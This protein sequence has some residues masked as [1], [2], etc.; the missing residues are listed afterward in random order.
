[1]LT[2]VLSFILALG[3]IV[4]VAA[5]QD[6]PEEVPPGWRTGVVAKL[7]GSQ[8]G[9]SNWQGGGINSLAFT[10]GV[11][12]EAKKESEKWQQAVN[13]R[14]G[15][16]AIKQDTLSMRKAEDVIFAAYNLQFK[17]EGFFGK[18]QPTFAADLR[19]QFLEG[20]DYGQQPEA[21]VSDLLAPA[22]LTQ[23]LG[24][25]YNVDD[26]FSQR[27]GFGAKQTVVTKEELR[28]LYG[29][30]PDELNDTA[31][32]EAGIES[33]TQLT[34]ELVKNVMYKST[35]SLFAAFNNPDKPDAIWE[36]LVTMKVNDWLQTNFEL[37][38]LY[39]DDVTS[40][41]QLKE[42]FSVGVAFTLL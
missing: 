21:K 17:G 6:A 4:P 32:I 29:F 11:D 19:T 38:L 23:A 10:A 7:A 37:V 25:T 41:V 39:D 34:R 1:M 31:R 9:F 28:P 13:V 36:N 24:L 2:R 14:L 12:G 3:L 26:W 22:Y 40:D 27:F 20:F 35:L 5:G 8:V 33:H 30:G 18:W 15:I 42:V 16:G